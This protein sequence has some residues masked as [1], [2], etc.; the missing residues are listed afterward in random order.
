MDEDGPTCRATRR[1]GEPCRAKAGASGYCFG[2]DP[3]LAQRHEEGRSV[4]GRNRAT[5]ARVGKLLQGDGEIVDVLSLLK[6]ALVETYAGALDARAAG[7]LASLSNALVRMHEIGTLELRIKALE[8][9][10]GDG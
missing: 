5:A 3:D 4:G 10:E 2:H 7:A 6:T 1:D 9:R 8:E